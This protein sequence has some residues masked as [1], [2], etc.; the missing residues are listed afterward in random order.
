[1]SSVSTVGYR[2]PAGGGLLDV[3]TRLCLLVLV[4]L[5]VVA[6]GLIIAFSPRASAPRS[7]GLVQAA[8]PP[9]A[10]APADPAELTASEHARRIEQVR[11][12]VL[13]WR[14]EH[15]ALRLAR[16]AVP[17]GRRLWTNAIV[18]GATPEQCLAQAIY[19][20]ARSEPDAGQAAVARVV[21]NRTH[22]PRYPK[23][24]CGVV[25][26]GASRPGCQFSFACEGDVQARLK[27]NPEAWRRASE[28]ARLA[29]SGGGTLDP[30]VSGATHYHTDRVAPRWDAGLTRLAQIGR[31]VFFGALGRTPDAQAVPASTPASSSA[32]KPA[33]WT[34]MIWGSGN[35]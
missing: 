10:S 7:P 32:R 23:S 6:V 8:S 31:H 20:E 14:L 11:A 22:D 30:S 17:S 5:G 21:L 25:F 34:D 35:A 12:R 19:Y 15:P 2:R 28:N 24:V 18:P 13:A 4:V 9:R 33:S 1:M 26:Q 29:L 3:L 27:I 16:R